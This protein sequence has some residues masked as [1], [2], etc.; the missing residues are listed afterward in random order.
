MTAHDLGPRHLCRG[1]LTHPLGLHC[2]VQ[3]DHIA[4]GRLLDG[5]LRAVE[6]G[7]TFL[8]T[9]DSYGCGHSERVIGRFLRE[10][11]DLPLRL[12]SKVG[13]VRGTAPHAFAGRHIHHQLEQSLENLYAE[14]LDLY[15]LD[16]FDF[17]RGDRYLGNAIDMMRTLR[18]LGSIKAIGMRGPHMD[19]AASPAQR[20]ARAERFLYLFRLI[21]PDV[22]WT[23][24]NAF[25]P[26]ILLEGEDLF[27]FTAR[28]GVGLVLAAPLAH[29]ALTGRAGEGVSSSRP[30]LPDLTRPTPRLTERVAEGLHTLQQRFGD[31]PGTLTRLALRWC[32]Q[33]GDHCVVVVGFSSEAQVQEN[34][35]CL[36]D[37]LTGHELA[38]VDEVY[39]RFR[40][41]LQEEPERHPAHEACEERRAG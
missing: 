26:A 13:Q 30:V 36:G 20:K 14:H 35:N 25:T 18:D 38:A 11:P 27:S 7:A 17:G 23:R 12:S 32:L 33:R 6:Q 19:Y 37:A 22:V 4:T 16:S 28:H 39:A 5:L 41:A 29:G 40:A 31:A 15:V 2:Q 34:Y 10:Y 3:P 24:F 8:D 9:A 1:I 21:K